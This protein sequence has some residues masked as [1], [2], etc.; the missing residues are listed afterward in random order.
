MKKRNWHV[1]K[2]FQD[3]SFIFL[4]SITFECK[5][6]SGPSLFPPPPP[7]RTFDI[8]LVPFFVFANFFPTEQHGRPDVRPVSVRVFLFAGIE[9][10]G[11]HELHVHGNHQELQQHEQV[12][13]PGVWC[14]HPGTTRGCREAPVLNRADKQEPH[15]VS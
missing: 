15:L 2:L 3:S 6:L 9:R 5:I 4:Y 10:R 14:C 1:D 8:C 11:L 12:F 13:L 7:P